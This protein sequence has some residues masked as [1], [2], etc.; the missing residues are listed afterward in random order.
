MAGLAAAL[1]DG[2]DVFGEGHLR[3]DRRQAG[4]RGVV[5]FS[6][7]GDRG[8]GHERGH[9]HDASDGYGPADVSTRHVLSPW[10]SDST[11]IRA[12]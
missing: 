9:E 3:R 8:E 1:Q 4:V 6:V 12:A 5:L 7:K 2:C 10:S 11:P